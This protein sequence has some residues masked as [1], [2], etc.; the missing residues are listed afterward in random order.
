MVNVETT[1]QRPFAMSA[2]FALLS[3]TLIGLATIFLS[4]SLTTF[5][6][7][8]LLAQ[9]KKDA[10]VVS[11]SVMNRIYE[12]AFKGQPFADSSLDI[13]FPAQLTQIQ[14]LFDG[15]S[16]SLGLESMAIMDREGEVIFSTF[17]NHIGDN[18]G[19][20]H[21]LKRALAGEACFDIIQ[22]SESPLLKGKQEDEKIQI[23]LPFGQGTAILYRSPKLLRQL[24]A[25]GVRAVVGTCLP[26]MVG[27]FALLAI[28]VWR[29]DRRLL[30]SAETVSRQ[31]EELKRNQLQMIRSNR[32]AAIGELAGGIAH[33]LNN[34][35]GG[36]RIY[37]EGLLRRASKEDLA[38]GLF[39][40]ESTKIFDKLIKEIDRCRD[41]IQNLL[42]FSHQDEER[43]A[44]RTDVNSVVKEILTL[45][46][47]RL[48]RSTVE[49][50]TE[51]D[52]Q[53]PQAALS[54]GE[55]GQVLM[56]VVT[57]SIQA[58]ADGGNL[59]I[60][61]SLLPQDKIELLIEDTGPGISDELKDRVLEPF[62]TTKAPGEGTGLGLSISYGIV[63]RRHGELCLQ[64]GESGGTTCYITLP[65][66][67]GE[68]I[69]DV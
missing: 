68:G 65:L 8:S 27:L 18:I 5:F 30:A 66:A 50:K 31:N 52:K 3:A 61:T 33:E 25:S 67:K 23:I 16:P 7:A 39:R 19:N 29:A 38:D 51:L 10:I 44:A 26:V 54:A 60:K 35:L 13:H 64:S 4:T 9:S 11:R 49:V 57:N 14:E 53:I 40:T 41:I 46:D 63:T 2:V 48:K 58:M 55:L 69:E 37:I 24:Q 56:N 12:A 15:L 1:S 20:Y 45:V 34:P 43:Q 21:L 17:P 6:E 22:A 59:T 32:L 47:L 36:M 42:T 62:F 28:F